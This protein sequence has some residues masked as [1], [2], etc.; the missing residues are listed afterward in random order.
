MMQ[1]L[2]AAGMLN[3]IPKVTKGLALSVCAHSMTVHFLRMF[4]IF[5]VGQNITMHTVCE[6]TLSTLR[7]QADPKA[8]RLA[9]TH[10]KLG[11]DGT[12]V[13]TK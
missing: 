10:V 11:A 12:N 9:A 5:E 13:W 2:E 6:D 8:M 1:L 7:H 3:C 4:L